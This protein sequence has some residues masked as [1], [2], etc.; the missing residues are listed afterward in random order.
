MS[1]D[2]AASGCIHC[3]LMALINQRLPEAA[4]F[5]LRMAVMIDIMAVLADL[6]A[7]IQPQESRDIIWAALVRNFPDLLKVSVDR[8]D[9]G[10]NLH[11]P[12]PGVH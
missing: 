1:H 7:T 6:L 5:E 2:R 10:G 11:R 8:R 12:L 4:S 3:A 9:G